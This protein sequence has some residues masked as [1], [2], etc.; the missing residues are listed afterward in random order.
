MEMIDPCVKIPVAVNS[1]G[2]WVTSPSLGSEK[3]S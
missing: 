2:Y 1:P 3:M